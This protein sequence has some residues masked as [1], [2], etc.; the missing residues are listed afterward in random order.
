MIEKDLQD[1]KDFLGFVR[2]E[3]YNLALELSMPET[4]QSM[5]DKLVL[6]ETARKELSADTI[7]LASVSKVKEEKPLWQKMA[8]IL[9]EKI[10]QFSPKEHKDKTLDIEQETEKPEK[11]DT[12]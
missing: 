1:A 5:A 3:A 11:A 6:S 4:I 9:D 7:E 10:K 12:K 2:I 8:D